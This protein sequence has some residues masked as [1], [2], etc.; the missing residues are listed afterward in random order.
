M[1]KMHNP[2]DIL[3]KEHSI[4]VEV[5]GFTYQIKDF[6]KS[7]PD[8]FEKILGEMINFFR[9]YADKY[10]HYK[11]E[12]VLFPRM[13]DEN[14]LVKEGIIQEMFDNH[15]EFRNKIKLIEDSLNTREFEKSFSILIEYCNM[16][17]DHIAVE[18]DELFQMIETLLSPSDIEKVYFSFL[19]IDRDLG[20]SQK[21][22]FESYPEKLQ[23]FFP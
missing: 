18:N 22:N 8:K 13:G 4:I 23:N 3:L 6:I 20:E 2:V 1:N 11:E 5:V 12:Q 15:I 19:D 14:E 7:D 9:N 10:H 17:L 21:S 16:L